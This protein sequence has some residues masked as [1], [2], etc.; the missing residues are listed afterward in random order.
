MKMVGG[1]LKMVCVE[2]L[3]SCSPA[4]SMWQSW[5]RAK[6]ISPAKVRS[7]GFLVEKTES[8]VTIVQTSDIDSVGHILCIPFCAVT[9]IERIKHDKSAEEE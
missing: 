1:K 7:I 5:E 2:W 3:D 8:H 4:G 9:K 6:N